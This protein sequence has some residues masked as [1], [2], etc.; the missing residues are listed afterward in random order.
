MSDEQLTA[1][2]NNI[3]R[4]ME[5]MDALESNLQQSHQY[6]SIPTE[7]TEAT[8]AAE[9]SSYHRA[10]CRQ[11]V[12]T[13]SRVGTI[14]PRVSRRF[15]QIAL[16]E[17]ERRRFLAECPRNLTCEYNAPTVNAVQMGSTYKRFGSQL[18]NIQF[19]LSG[20]TRPSD[21]SLHEVIQHGSVYYQDAV[22]FVNVIHGLLAGTASHITQL[23][24][25]NM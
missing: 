3:M 10:L 18:A 1:L 5:R 12:P 20:I 25:D 9:P 8:V 7:K 22:E 4:L 11:R 17:L 21:L 15:L 19:R 24:V 23:R 14:S 2:Q 13:I 16:P 6:T